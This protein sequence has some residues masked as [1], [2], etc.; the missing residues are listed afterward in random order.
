MEVFL[1]SHLNS[2]ILL[3]DVNP[4]ELEENTSKQA[5]EV[6]GFL[7]DF[8][9]T[10]AKAVKEI[11]KGQSIIDGLRMDIANA[12]T[13]FDKLMV[14][15]RMRKRHETSLAKKSVRKN[16]DAQLE[17]HPEL[18]MERAVALNIEREMHEILDKYED[19][20]GGAA[21]EE[22]WQGKPSGNE[23]NAALASEQAANKVRVT[24]Y[25]CIDVLADII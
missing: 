19:P 16:L 17:L 18:S 15:V 10:R 14:L 9:T 4:Q 21:R 2:S 1:Y 3:P 23:K 12:G 7:K 11:G 5:Q 25:N 8:V 22:R 24:F 20:S 6:Q 13:Q